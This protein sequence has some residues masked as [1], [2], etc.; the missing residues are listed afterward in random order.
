MKKRQTA[1]L[2]LIFSFFII[3]Q[4]MSKS[5]YD[6]ISNSHLCILTNNTVAAMFSQTEEECVKVDQEIKVVDWCWIVFENRV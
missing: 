3:D 1:S 6:S 4:K 5:C 2:N